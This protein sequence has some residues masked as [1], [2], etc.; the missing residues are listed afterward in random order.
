MYVVLQVCGFLT[1]LVL[2]FVIPF[3]LCW[4]SD[5]PNFDCYLANY[6]DFFYIFE[7]LVWNSIKS[8][9]TFLHFFSVMTVRVRVQKVAVTRKWVC[10]RLNLSRPCSLV[11]LCKRKQIANYNALNARRLQVVNKRHLVWQVH[12][13]LHLQ[14]DKRKKIQVCFFYEFP[15]FFFPPKKPSTTEIQLQSKHL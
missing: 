12:P 5:T 1:N 3:H 14:H 13:H 10:N 7:A 4:F 9:L 2:L 8:A 15:W 11:F 6:V